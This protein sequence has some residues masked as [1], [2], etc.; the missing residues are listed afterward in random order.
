MQRP[1][2]EPGSKPWEGLRIPLSHRCLLV[3]FLLI[4]FFNALFTRAVKYLQ[5]V[6]VFMTSSY[7]P[8]V[9]PGVLEVFSGPMKS[10]KSLALLHRVEK[11]KY[12]KGEKFL[13]FKPKLDTR[14]LV[15][16]SRFGSLSHD[17]IFVNEHIPEEIFS[18]VES[19]TTLVAIDEVHFFGSKIVPVIL[20]LLKQNKNVIA[21]GLDTDFRGEPFGS[22]PVL[23]SL[24]DEVYKLNGI[25]DF[26]DCR[27]PAS[28]TQRL[29]N[30]VPADY[31]SLII[32][33]GD[34]KEGYQCRCL[35]H[36]EVPNAPVFSFDIFPKVV[37]KKL[38]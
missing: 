7:H 14:D 9:K 13:V 22:L 23:L 2:I 28:R 18:H 24:A 15:V 34:E 29:V 27:A 4:R 12:M 10:G 30:G 36:H 21:A 35:A 16:R 31:Y 5:I 20:E 38:E 19:D 17:C 33:V 6:F 1:G 37:Q 25:C 26:P 3:I 8:F 11:L 32:L